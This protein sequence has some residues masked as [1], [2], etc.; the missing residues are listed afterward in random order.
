MTTTDHSPAIDRP[1]RIEERF[2]GSSSRL[3]R[4][5]EGVIGVDHGAL[6]IGTLARPGRGRAVVAYGPVDPAPGTTFSTL[7]LNGDQA[8]AGY[9]IDSVPRRFAR[10]A[11]GSGTFS[12]LSR[13]IHYPRF[14]KRESIVRKLRYWSANRAGHDSADHL[15]NLA[16]GWFAGPDAADPARGGGI[17]VRSAGPFSGEVRTVGPAGPVVAFDDLQN[18]PVHWVLVQ[19]EQGVLCLAGSSHEGANRLPLTP[20]VRPLGIVPNG[21]S[22]YAVIDQGCSGQIGFSSDTRILGA[23]VDRWDGA[24]GW[25]TTA[26]LADRLTGTGPC[27]TV[28]PQP[29]QCEEGEWLRSG[30][31]LVSAAPRSSGTTALPADPGLVHLRV[32][33]DE[34]SAIE[35]TLDGSS[36]VVTVRVAE[37]GD[38]LLASGSHAVQLLVLDDALRWTAGPHLAGTLDLPRPWSDPS[39]TLVGEAA[40]G[41]IRWRDLEVHPAR[42]TLPEHLRHSASSIPLGERLVLHEPFALSGDELDGQITDGHRWV[43]SLGTARIVDDPAGAAVVDAS[44]ER[45]APDRTI[46][47]IDWHDPDHADL[48]IEGASPG[49]PDDEWQR[50]RIGVVLWQDA[51]HHVMTNIWIDDWYESAS[52]STFFVIDGFEDIYDAVWAN[53]GRRVQRCQPFRL[54]LV[55]DGA[56]F[57]VLLDDEP[58]LH[59]R[60][61]DVYP[62]VDRLSINRVGIVTNWEWGHDT[63]SRITAFRARSRT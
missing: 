55:S 10:W 25:S 52:A 26:A 13:L 17:V 46:H 45:P 18:L 32:E 24:T 7:V 41:S 5:E 33:V 58:V 40:P 28:G 6:R 44:R 23:T 60:I 62:R 8:S 1:V 43:R 30:D 49:Q 57:D 35:V 4:D 2:D 3:V 27:T 54:R 15:D 47:T 16:V 56:A 63:G 22:R 31:G 20:E 53:L 9:V 59:R 36:A 21:V 37:T 11:L 42:I 48:E 19:R 29:W 14:R 38:G 51:D 50:S 61:S 12:P 39:L 34:P